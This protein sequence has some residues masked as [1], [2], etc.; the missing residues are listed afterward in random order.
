[1]RAFLISL[2]FLFVVGCHEDAP[3]APADSWG[4]RYIADKCKRSPE[5][6]TL[7]ADATPVDNADA[8]TPS[9]D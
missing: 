6:C 4:D 9:T 1:M 8:A 2:L 5:T 7:P 3:T